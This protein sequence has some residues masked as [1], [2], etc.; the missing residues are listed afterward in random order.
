MPS[1]NEPNVPGSAPTACQCG[2][3]VI[4]RNAPPHWPYVMG[5]SALVRRAI[6][7]YR[8]HD[9]LRTG[10]AIAMA[11]DALAAYRADTAAGKDALLVCDTTE[12]ADAL[13]QRVHHDTVG[14]DAP[15]ITGA[16]GHRIAVGDLIISRQNDV[17]I[18]LSNTDQP[19][20]QNSPVRNGHRWCVTTI[21]PDNNRLL[22]RR[23]DD[24]TLGGFFGD[25]VRE[26]ITYG[27][28]FTVHSA[29]GVTA[30][31]A[32]AVLSEAA[33]RTLTYVAMSRGRDANTAYIYAHT[34][35]HEYRHE[36]ARTVH[37]VQR[38]NSHRAG[39]LLRAIVANDQQPVTAH[40]VA[41]K[42]ADDSLPSR[43]RAA[44][45]R[46][47]VAIRDRATDYEHWLSGTA[48]F[49]TAMREA[50]EHHVAFSR[51]VDYGIGL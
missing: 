42:T 3:C 17:S 11:G 24:N 43:V 49:T 37:V 12:M 25:Y 47:A 33:D 31:T 7:W 50:P 38:G 8:T 39:Q 32:Y 48:T 2:A 16:R 5:G 19:A 14:A 29:Q 20:A 41:I 23:L 45:K 36:P 22:A 51:S 9:R 44:N 27:Y 10:D 34:P 28:A 35:E 1:A 15:T 18:P 4:R 26:H 30:D 6:G 40:N 46:R 13:N 21:N